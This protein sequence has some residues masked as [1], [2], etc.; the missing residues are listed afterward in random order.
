MQRTCRTEQWPLPGMSVAR[1]D[2]LVPAWVDHPERGRVA[3]PAARL[4]GGSLL[5]NG[6]AVRYQDLAPP[7]P[8]SPAMDADGRA[9]LQVLSY[10]G[11]DGAATGLAAVSAPGPAAAA[12]T[13]A[14]ERWAA[15]MRTRRLV[16]GGVE[17]L[18]A[19]VRRARAVVDAVAESGRPTVVLA[20]DPVA[21]GPVIGRG[22]AV[23]GTESAAELE[24]ILDGAVVVVGPA[25]VA[26]ALRARIAAQGRTPV[27]AVCPLALAAQ[28]EVRRFAQ[29]GETVVLVGRNGHGAVPALLGQAAAGS[30]RLV[31]DLAQARQLE[32]ADPGRVAVVLQPGLPLGEAES[33]AE[34]VRKRFGHVL[35]Q[36]PSTYCH[37]ADDRLRALTQLARA[38]AVVL[39]TGPAASARETVRVIEQAGAAAYAVL[40]PEGVRPGW[41]KGRASVGVTAAAG[42]EPGLVQALVR[43]LSGLGPCA[44][45]L[46][47]GATVASTT[48]DAMSAVAGGTAAVEQDP[49]RA[50]VPV[51]T[52]PGA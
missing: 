15:V 35:P 21:A 52:Q 50:L 6:L 29:Q 4:L 14:L 42:A 9:V 47:E 17:P 32:V 37:A 5:R 39:V 10:L 18:C 7:S 16:V 41:L 49:G 22:S 27:D 20:P 11:R 23:R 8:P 30:V 31:E 12:V 45:E 38:C 24:H 36:H 3:C 26:P 25:G 46:Q 1:G 51:R 43:T 33:V 34:A 28:A 48:S 13:A 40:G 2:V 44:V 19:G